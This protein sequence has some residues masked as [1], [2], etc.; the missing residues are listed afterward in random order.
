MHAEVDEPV[1]ELVR[2]AIEDVRELVRLEVALAVRETRQ[3]VARAKTAGIALGAA[4]AL[5]LSALALMFVAV[6]AAFAPLWLAALVVAAILLAVAGVLALAG[7]RA[8]PRKPLEETRGRI[9]SDV[10]QLRERI[11]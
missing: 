7:A 10:E 8:L 2:D 4:A 6:A 9:R 1:G 3:S 11:A 5:G